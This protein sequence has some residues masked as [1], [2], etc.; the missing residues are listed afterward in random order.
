[1]SSHINEFLF[2][3]PP[4][5]QY[6]LSLSPCLCSSQSKAQKDMKLVLLGSCSS[7]LFIICEQN[8]QQIPN[9]IKNDTWKEYPSH[10]KAQKPGD[11][12]DSN[13]RNSLHYHHKNQSSKKNDFQ[14]NTFQDLVFKF[15]QHQSSLIALLFVMLKGKREEKGYLIGGNVGE[16]TSPFY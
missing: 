9:L 10:A 8:R 5:S 14:T 3:S 12:P 6:Y 2:D 11:N 1:M 7:S 16:D 15:L 13:S 4:V